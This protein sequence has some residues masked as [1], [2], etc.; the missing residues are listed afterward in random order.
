MRDA[1]LDAFEDAVDDLADRVSEVLADGTDHTPADIEADVD[2]MPH[3]YY[4]H[5]PRRDSEVRTASI[6]KATVI[7]LSTLLT[8]LPPS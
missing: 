6:I 5:P 3:L 4:V 1:E 7:R 8:A 2:I